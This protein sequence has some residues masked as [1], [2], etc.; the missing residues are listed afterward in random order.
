MQRPAMPLGKAIGTFLRLSASFSGRA[1]PSSSWWAVPFGA[2]V[3]AV[4]AT[5]DG[6]M[7][8]PSPQ[9]ARDPSTPSSHSRWSCPR[10]L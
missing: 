9:T 6:A 4:A 2:L 10:S 7:G 1:R 3:G 8:T 5:V